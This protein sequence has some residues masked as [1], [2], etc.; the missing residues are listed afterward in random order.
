[1]EKREYSASLEMFAPVWLDL[2][3]MDMQESP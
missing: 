2:A 1:V 3:V